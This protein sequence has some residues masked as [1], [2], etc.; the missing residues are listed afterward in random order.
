MSHCIIII[1]K[2]PKALRFRRTC[3]VHGKD[4]PV[5]FFKIQSDSP[6]VSNCHSHFCEW[7]FPVSSVSYLKDM[8]FSAFIQR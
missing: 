1:P 6:K 3:T 5:L 8:I 4:L 7:Q 2:S